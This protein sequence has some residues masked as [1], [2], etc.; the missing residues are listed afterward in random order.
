M[1]EIGG[2]LA[3]TRE[4]IP[5]GVARLLR[6]STFTI[7]HHSI[8]AEVFLTVSDHYGLFSVSLIILALLYAC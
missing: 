2:H 6:N 4:T 5:V 7:L 1:S 8:L 3:I